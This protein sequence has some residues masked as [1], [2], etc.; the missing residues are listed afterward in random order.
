MP[1]PRKK[2]AAK[3]P[4]KPKKPVIAE[5]YYITVTVEPAALFLY[6][7]DTD[8]AAAKWF[9]KVVKDAGYAESEDYA[10][11][12]FLDESDSDDMIVE[13]IRPMESVLDAYVGGDE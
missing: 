4:S 8:R 7:P 10:E 6:G 5:G 11:V 13:E 3:K 2:A 9:R 12:R 1:A